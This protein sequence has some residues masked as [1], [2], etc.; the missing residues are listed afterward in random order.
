MNTDIEKFTEIMF[1]L[2]FY[3]RLLTSE[4]EKYSPNIIE[5]ADK[6]V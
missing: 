2:N 3:Y 6:V 1:G 5:K 4:N